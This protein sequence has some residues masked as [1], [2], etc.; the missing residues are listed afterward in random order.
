[1]KESSRDDADD[2]VHDQKHSS[3]NV[4]VLGKLEVLPAD[5]DALSSSHTID[6]HLC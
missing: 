2:H 5:V 4:G 3:G 1:M 6:K